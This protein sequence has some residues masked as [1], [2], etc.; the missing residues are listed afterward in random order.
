MF[1]IFNLIFIRRFSD[2]VQKGHQSDVAYL[3]EA[4]N[5]QLEG[6][7]QA[8]TQLQ[9]LKETKRL[10]PM[11]DHEA[12][13]NTV[14]FDMIEDVKYTVSSNN[15]LE[16]L[17]I[18]YPKSDYVVGNIGSF[19]SKNY[20]Y[21]KEKEIAGYEKW[22]AMVTQEGFGY[23]IVDDLVQGSTLLLKKSMPLNSKKDIDYILV[24]E[25]SQE[26]IIKLLEVMTRT[27]PRTLIGIEAYTIVG[28]D[29]LIT[30]YQDYKHHVDIKNEFIVIKENIGTQHIEMTLIS[31]EKEILANVNTIRNISY[32]FLMIC[33]GVG[34][35][36]AYLLVKNNLKP[37][38]YMVKS[39]NIPD[40]ENVDELLLIEKQIDRLLE[41]NRIKRRRANKD[42]IDRVL[43]YAEQDYAEISRLIKRYDVDL[44]YT[45]FTFA[46]IVFL[47]PFDLGEVESYFDFIEKTEEKATD[48]SLIASK[49]REK[50]VLLI[51]H[52][53]DEIKDRIIKQVYGYWQHKDKKIK[54]GVSET[55]DQVA[56]IAALSY[57]A[58]RAAIDELKQGIN[59][60]QPDEGS[61]NNTS[62]V[63]MKWQKHLLNKQYKEASYMTP[64]VVNT[65]LSKQLYP[66]IYNGRKYA[67]TNQVI[68]A[69]N[70][71]ACSDKG[72][73]ISMLL[74]ST[75]NKQLIQWIITILDNLGHTCSV[76]DETITRLGEN[77]KQIIETQY[78]SSDLC[79][80]YISEQLNV[81]TSYISRN[82]KK[83][84]GV[85]VVEYMNRKRIDQAKT[86]LVTHQYTIK[87]IANKVGFSSDLN[88][89]RV[90]KKYEKMTPGQFSDG[91]GQG[92]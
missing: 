49:D 64:D 45:Y 34:G 53:D 15:F 7:N 82:F 84:Y 58:H 72:Y 21:L 67:V 2:S 83:C 39:L 22:L 75:E 89:I 70:Q 17:Y 33:L 18:Y 50:I 5:L 78:H 76:P 41:E 85:G 63:F 88:F 1:L 36:L 19:N 92:N 91:K 38:Q 60:Y 68:E 44:I 27:K 65:Y 79:L 56:T 11:T 59:Y 73:Y 32:L 14:L 13:K 90:F 74:S 20:Y 66:V 71:E 3:K 30:T 80:T 62:K 69:L 86:Y 51:N 28:D 8:T 87:D 52:E 42:F 9:L 35:I 37:I 12:F 47:E 24:A 40:N 31:S 4:I 57:Q 25:V 77:I 61:G 23:Q 16:N 48:F 54:M 46:S 55:T 81:S 26:A 10:S 43:D 29:T 6:I